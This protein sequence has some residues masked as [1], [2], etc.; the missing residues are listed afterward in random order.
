MAR[1]YQCDMCGVVTILKDTHLYADE[2]EYL[3]KEPAMNIYYRGRD[4]DI[5]SN[6]ARKVIALIDERKDRLNENKS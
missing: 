3:N 1:C 2:E 6:C 4:I 5:C